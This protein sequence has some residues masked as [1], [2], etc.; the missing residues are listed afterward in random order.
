[1][2]TI[3]IG[4]R[5]SKMAMI[6][7]NAF[8][9]ALNQQFPA[10]SDGAIDIVPIKTTGC[11]ILNK[12]LAEIGGKGLFIKE[13]EQALEG[14]VI[15]VGVHCM[16]DVPSLMLEGFD[17]PV[18][19]PRDDPRDCFISTKAKSL[20]DL[21]EGATLGTSSPRRAAI[22]LQKRPD[23]KITTFRGNA[24]KRLEKLKAG[25][26]DATY[27]S[28][29][30][31]ERLG[32]L[33][34]LEGKCVFPVPVDDMLPACG[35][36]AIGVEILST[37]NEMRDFLAPMNCVDTYRAVMAERSCLV[38]LDGDCH[39]PLAA[40]ATISENV[41]TLRAQALRPDGSEYV[42]DTITGPVESYQD[43]G[44]TL[45]Q[46]IKDQLPDDFFDV[47]EASHVERSPVTC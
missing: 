39:S 15:D 38:E 45:G 28:Y 16:K 17:I 4:T 25:E 9:D 42:D 33:K 7:A 32:L 31:L 2:K 35:Q 30:G 18:L 21:P 22:S 12:K 36:G 26:V 8:R 19:M 5:G 20:E 3:R 27:L 13:L 23:I 44:Q 10:M 34:E 46:R 41:L 11:T 29:S 37:Q 24:D 14:G 43:L 1:M 40:Y 6:Q 47:C